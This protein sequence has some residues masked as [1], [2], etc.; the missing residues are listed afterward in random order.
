M[1]EGEQTLLVTR[2]TRLLSFGFYV[3]FVILLGAAVAFILDLVPVPEGI[4]VPFL[5]WTLETTAAAVLGTLSLLSSC[6]RSSD[7]R[8]PGT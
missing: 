4:I 2:P 5:G 8:A 6:T 1:Y 3:L 7:G